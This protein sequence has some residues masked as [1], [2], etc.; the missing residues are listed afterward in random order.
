MCE[1]TSYDKDKITKDKLYQISHKLFKHKDIIE[2]GL[3]QKTNELFDI[4]D[5]VIIY[6]LTNTYFEG[7]M[8]ESKMA[9]FGRSKEKRSDAKLIVLALVVNQQGFIKYSKLMEGNTSDSS[10]LL[11]IIEDLTVNTSHLERKPIE[12]GRAHV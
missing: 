11:D 12:I 7:R 1:I 2:Q 3:S 10:S 5:K 8:Q 6:D 4:E 9:K